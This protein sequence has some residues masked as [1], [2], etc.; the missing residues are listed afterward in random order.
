MASASYSPK[1]IKVRR[2]VTAAR[3]LNNG[4]HTALPAKTP[5][6]RADDNMRSAFEKN[7]AA[8]NARV[9]SKQHMGGEQ[10]TNASDDEE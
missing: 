10:A 6:Q 1:A 7:T 9:L 2:M 4:L 8:T 5:R 3:A